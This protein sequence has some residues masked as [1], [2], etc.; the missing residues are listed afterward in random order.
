[1]TRHSK[2]QSRRSSGPLVIAVCL[3]LA[4]AA[5]LTTTTRASDNLDFAIN[6]QVVEIVWDSRLFDG[7]PGFPGAIVWSHNRSGIPSNLDPAAFEATIDASFNTWESVDNGVP[8][9]PLVPV[10]NFAGQS[11]ATDA[12]AL[13]G[14]SAG[15]EDLRG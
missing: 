11:T 10:V 3:L 5:G 9:E 1:M 2:K 7:T 6:G 12:F 8:E 4:V 15:R 14:V 13:D